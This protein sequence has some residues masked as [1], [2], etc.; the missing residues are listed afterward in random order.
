METASCSQAAALGILREF[1]IH[2]CSVRL[3]LILATSVAKCSQMSVPDNA[4]I[5]I[6]LF[7]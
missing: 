3:R 1:H 2:T 5:V 7:S 4:I 6:L